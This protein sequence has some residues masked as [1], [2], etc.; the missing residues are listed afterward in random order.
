[1][2]GVPGFS[3]TVDIAQE[4][5]K[6]LGPVTAQLGVDRDIAAAAL[7]AGGPPRRARALGRLRQVSARRR[8]KS[9]GDMLRQHIALDYRTLAQDLPSSAASSRPW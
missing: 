6:P 4:R 1:M 5:G 7:I 8:E 3:D 2:Y 9:V